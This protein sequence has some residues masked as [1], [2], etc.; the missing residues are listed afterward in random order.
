MT[1]LWK[2]RK[3]EKKFTHIHT[4]SN[5]I[6]LSYSFLKT[7]SGSFRQVDKKDFSCSHFETTI[8]DYVEMNVTYMNDFSIQYS[9]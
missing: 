9:I 2:A 3:L 7:F 8:N 4:N 1:L 6:K 5:W